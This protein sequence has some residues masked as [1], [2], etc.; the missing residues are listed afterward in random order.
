[1]YSSGRMTLELLLMN[2]RDEIMSTDSLARRAELYMTVRDK[3]LYFSDWEE[4][5]EKMIIA[6]RHNIG[7]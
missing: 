4:G 7:N 1:M 6:R 5:I 2:R 3:S